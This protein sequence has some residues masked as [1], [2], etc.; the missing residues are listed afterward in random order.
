MWASSVTAALF[1]L[2]AVRAWWN[3]EPDILHGQQAFSA[4]ESVLGNEARD[5]PPVAR[6]RR[7]LERAQ[8]EWRWV[9]SHI[10]LQIC[11]CSLQV[12]VVD[13][14]C[15]PLQ[16][17]KHFLSFTTTLTPETVAFL[18]IVHSYCSQIVSLASPLPPRNATKRGVASLDTRH[19][20]APHSSPR[21]TRCGYYNGHGEWIC[22][23]GLCGP[24]CIITSDYRQRATWSAG[25]RMGTF[26]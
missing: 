20:P 12:F 18:P 17:P 16:C 13:W 19:L 2:S 25:E 21:P 3:I 24:Q 26:A 23:E 22:W 11:R 4:V 1:T 6:W 14:D 8:T 5:G 15:C 9:V 10:V 7:K